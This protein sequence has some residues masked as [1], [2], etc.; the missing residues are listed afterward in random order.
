MF[1]WLRRKSYL[2]C[3]NDKFK[4]TEAKK[5][6]RKIN[7]SKNLHHDLGDFG[8]EVMKKVAKEN[9][10]GNDISA[11]FKRGRNGID[12]TVKG[13][14]NYS[15]KQKLGGEKYFKDMLRRSSK[16]YKNMAKKKK[17]FP[18]L[19]VDYIRVN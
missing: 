2:S 10:L 19:K 16:Q 7:N 8:E 1:W 6:E 14:F 13:K 18:E 4:L 12:G 5:Y 11:M 17:Q 15:S 9:N 3:F